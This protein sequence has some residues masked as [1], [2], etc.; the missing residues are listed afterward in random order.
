MKAIL[1]DAK[2]QSVQEVHYDDNI[3]H[4]KKLL[5]CD[6]FTVPVQLDNGDA[7]YV[8]DESLLKDPS[9][10]PGAFTFSEYPYQMLFGHGLIL[11]T[12]DQGDSQDYQS[13]IDDVT[14]KI[15]FFTM[16][17]AK[18]SFTTLANTPVQVYFEK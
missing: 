11:G 15:S 14:A 16:D 12:N 13:R 5:E 2:N 4:I 18:D 9:T 10:L 1:I 3:E 8:D 6:Y 17:K 7:L